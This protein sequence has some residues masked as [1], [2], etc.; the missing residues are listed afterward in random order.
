ML[1]EKTQSI[2][3]QDLISETKKFW[4]LNGIER[5]RVSQRDKTESRR[6]I[7]L[8]LRSAITDEIDFNYCQS[9]ECGF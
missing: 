5:I 4:Q 7:I 6:R 1:N 3:E 2:T 8:Q 9:L